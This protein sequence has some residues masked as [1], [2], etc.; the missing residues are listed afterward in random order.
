MRSTSIEAA[1]V[2]VAMTITITSFGASTDVAGLTRG[3]IHPIAYVPLVSGRGRDVD[4]GPKRRHH[5]HRTDY[6]RHRDEASVIPPPT[7]LVLF[8]T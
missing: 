2:C 1:L 6:V 5:P 8:D 4:P 7:P 3:A